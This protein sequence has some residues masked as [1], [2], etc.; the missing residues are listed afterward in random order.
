MTKKFILKPTK[1]VIINIEQDDILYLKLARINRSAFMR[2][3]IKAY[4]DG[5]FQYIHV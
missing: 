2:Q 1:T 4:K 5:K 3:A